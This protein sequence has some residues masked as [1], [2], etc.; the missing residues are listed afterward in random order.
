M[1]PDDWNPEGIVLNPIRL[2]CGKPWSE[3][4]GA[5]GNVCPDGLVWCCICFERFPID[6]LTTE[7]NGDKVDVCMGCTI[8]EATYINLMDIERCKHGTAS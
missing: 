7:P 8:D 5:D 1:M 4:L 3:H 2:C 6:Q